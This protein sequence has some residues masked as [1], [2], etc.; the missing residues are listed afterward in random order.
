MEFLKGLVCAST[1]MGYD[2]MIQWG[3]IQCYTLGYYCIHELSHNLTPMGLASQG[4]S[5]I[6]S[7]LLLLAANNINIGICKEIINS[8]HKCKVCYICACK[9]L[10]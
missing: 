8:P 2:T 7:T 5:I 6:N 3:M 10:L 1:I 9:L 4:D